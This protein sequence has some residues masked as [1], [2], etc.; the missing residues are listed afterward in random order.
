MYFLRGM[1]FRTLLLHFCHLQ[2]NGGLQLVTTGVLTIC[3]AADLYD[4]CVQVTQEVVR[5]T[6]G[7]SF[8]LVRKLTRNEEKLPLQRGASLLA[9][10][11]FALWWEPQGAFIV[12]SSR[13]N[14][15]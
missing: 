9:S 5:S 10:Y 11:L 7:E 4:C 6:N 2:H 3:K 1:F 14:S 8:I 13:L 12:S 15:H